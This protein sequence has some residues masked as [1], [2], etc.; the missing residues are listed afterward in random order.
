MIHLYIINKVSRAAMYGIGTYV[1]QLESFLSDMEGLRMNV[2]SMRSDAHELRISHKNNIRYIDVPDR[3][4]EHLY[5][6][7]EQARKY[8]KSVMYILKPHIE[9]DGKLIFQLNYIY[10]PYYPDLFKQFFP[11]CKVITTIHYIDWCFTLNGNTSY[12]KRII[13][14]QESSI[15]DQRELEINRT[16]KVEKEFFQKVDCIICL[17]KYTFGLLRECYDIPEEKISLVYNG[18]QDEYRKRS[19]EEIA[20]LKEN[21]YILPQE[22]I[23]LFVGRLDSI[24]GLNFLLEALKK[25]ITVVPDCRLLVVGGGDFKTYVE[26][27]GPVWNKITWFGKVD[28]DQLYHF[29]QLADIGVM[30][31]MH[32]QC[33]YVAIE[34]MMHGLPFIGTDSTGLSE[35]ISD[36]KFKIHLLETEKE[37]SLSS[38][39]LAASLMDYLRLDEDDQSYYRNEVRAQYEKEYTI[40]KMKNKLRR[41]F[42][43]L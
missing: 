10:R 6:T 39:D 5:E 12:F 8:L 26:Q 29:Y 16:F 18:L 42:D 4:N 27:G 23:L 19:L 33:S 32:E 9:T 3:L 41:V 7:E 36:E 38:D 37:V 35:M 17:S 14:M 40:G 13:G 28:K 31:S 21:Y 22:K 34:M 30:P 2:I 20:L 25:V 24:K 43:T 11:C 15:Q 1:R